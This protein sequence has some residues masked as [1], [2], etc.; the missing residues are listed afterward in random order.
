MMCRMMKVSIAVNFGAFEFFAC[1]SD[2]SDDESRPRTY[3]V[4]IQ[5]PGGIEQQNELMLT[6]DY[7]KLAVTWVDAETPI[8]DV[9]D[10]HTPNPKATQ[11]SILSDALVSARLSIT[12]IISLL[13]VPHLSFRFVN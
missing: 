10:S 11:N 1:V 4:N 7:R 2:F 6:G 9:G 13:Q 8:F 3:A 5:K 12:S